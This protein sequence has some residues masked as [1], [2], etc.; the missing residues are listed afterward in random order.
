MDN[1]FKWLGQNPLCTEAAYPYT[2]GNGISGTCKTTC[3]GV[4]TVTGHSDVPGE[5]AMLAA[6]GKGPMSVAIEAD[7]NAFQLYKVNQRV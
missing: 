3:S 1:A 5:S 7:K 6:I 2:S 4:V